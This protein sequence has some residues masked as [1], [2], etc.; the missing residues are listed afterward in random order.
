M[1]PGVGT[2]DRAIEVIVEKLQSV[3]ALAPVPLARVASGPPAHAAP[4]PATP[5]A[6]ARATPAALVLASPSTTASAVVTVTA[7][8][9]SDHTQRV[10]LEALEK[11]FKDT[12]VSR[13]FR[14]NSF[15][16][17]GYSVNNSGGGALSN[18]PGL[19]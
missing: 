14:I 1:V 10:V 15:H 11:W 5:A 6:V 7:E 2:E 8:L 12:P 16:E 18:F 17:W 13:P 3:N 19:Q 4:A 9:V